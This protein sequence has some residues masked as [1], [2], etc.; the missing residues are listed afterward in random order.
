MSGTELLLGGRESS[1]ARSLC[2]ALHQHEGTRLAL[3]TDFVNR[4]DCLEVIRSFNIMSI[5]SAFCP[6]NENLRMKAEKGILGSR[7]F[8]FSFALLVCG[9]PPPPKLNP[10]NTL[11]QL[12]YPVGPL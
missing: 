10:P 11:W 12:Q 3:N 8:A 9:V 7:S 6:L 4:T 1:T 2:S 5:Q